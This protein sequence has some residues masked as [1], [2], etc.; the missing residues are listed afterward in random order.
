M[1]ESPRG[2]AMSARFMRRRQLSNIRN[3]R[4]SPTPASAARGYASRDHANFH[5]RQINFISSCPPDPQQDKRVE[6][7]RKKHFGRA[8]A[9]R[10]DAPILSFLVAVNSIRRDKSVASPLFAC[11]PALNCE[12]YPRAAEGCGRGEFCVFGC[13]KSWRRLINLADRAPLAGRRTQ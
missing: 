7:P 9:R 11:K 12:A 2:G 3:V 8:R 5:A 4:F 13:C 1:S 6:D 10:V